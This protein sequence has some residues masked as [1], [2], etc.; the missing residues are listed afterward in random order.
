[1]FKE[2]VS[3]ESIVKKTRAAMMTTVMD[4]SMNPVRFFMEN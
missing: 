1:M 4:I 3:V 2:A